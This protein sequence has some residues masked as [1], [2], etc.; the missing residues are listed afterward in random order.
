MKILIIGCGFLGRSIQEMLQKKHFVTI[1]KT[2]PISIDAI[3]FRLLKPA[4]YSKLTDL[5]KPFDVI[6]ITASAGK[7]KT[8]AESYLLLA[9]RLKMALKTLS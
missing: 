2:H 6:I 8:Y 3:H 1:T 9:R 5:I 7:N 4:L